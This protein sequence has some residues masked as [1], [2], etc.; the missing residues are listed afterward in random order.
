MNIIER[1]TKTASKKAGEI[2]GAA[3]EKIEDANSGMDMQ[4]QYLFVQ[5]VMKDENVDYDTAIEFCTVGTP[6]WQPKYSLGYKMQSPHVTF[7][8][9]FEKGKAAFKKDLHPEELKIF[10]N[11][12]EN[13]NMSEMFIE[14]WKK[15]R[16][17]KKAAKKAA[18]HRAFGLE[19]KEKKGGST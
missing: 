2:K 18:R 6:K 8:L 10:E 9:Q 15:Q 4:A 11:E 13:M 17:E 5:S 16:K 1:I 7:M 19:V 12:V 14:E 3:W